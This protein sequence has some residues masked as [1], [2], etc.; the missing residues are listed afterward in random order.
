MKPNPSSDTKEPEIVIEAS[1]PVVQLST[2]DYFRIHTLN[3]ER[4]VL[5]LKTFTQLEHLDGLQKEITQA[6]G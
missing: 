6:D 5:S 1:T 2:G 3:I 4:T